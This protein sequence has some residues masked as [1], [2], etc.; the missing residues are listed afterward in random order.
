VSVNVVLAW[1]GVALWATW[2]NALSEELAARLLGV[3][4]PDLGIVLLVVFAARVRT[5]YLPWLAPVLALARCASSIEPL[6]AELA[7]CLGAVGAMR[8]LRAGLDLTPRLAL[9]AATG[10]LAAGWTVWLAWIAQLRVDEHFQRAAL[11]APATLAGWRAA[12]EFAPGA[13]SSALAALLLAPLVRRL[14]GLSV[15]EGRRPWQ[16]AAS[17]R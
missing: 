13:L 14:P 17:L 4:A 9:A 6:F 8:A 15:L 1:C 11:D 7:A 16:V 10:A 3:W 12:L 2:A 5:S